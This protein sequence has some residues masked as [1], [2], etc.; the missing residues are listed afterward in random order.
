MTLFCC[1]ELVDQQGD[2]KVERAQQAKN[3]QHDVNFGILD[4]IWFNQLEDVSIFQLKTYARPYSR[5]QGAIDSLTLSSSGLSDAWQAYLWQITISKTHSVSRALFKVLDN[6]PAQVTSVVLCFV[7]PIEV[8]AHWKWMRRLPETSDCS[9]RVASLM[10]NIRQEVMLL[11]EEVIRNPN[12]SFSP[13]NT[14]L[15][16]PE[17]DDDFMELE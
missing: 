13:L 16:T 9:P 17:P 6:L 4:T 12:K 11:P 1:R 8:F 3:R 15:T 2:D 7:V 10:R 5:T 14:G